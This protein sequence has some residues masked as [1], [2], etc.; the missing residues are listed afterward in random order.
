MKQ[1]KLTKYLFFRKVKDKFRYCSYCGKSIKLKQFTL[2]INQPLMSGFVFIHFDCIDNF[3][4]DIKK[5]AKENQRD[6]TLSNI[7][8][9]L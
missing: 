8:E 4:K 2:N 3:A 9:S 7:T 1:I 5:F 6:I